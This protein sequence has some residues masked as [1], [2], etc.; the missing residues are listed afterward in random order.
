MVNDLPADVTVEALT[1]AEI[2]AMRRQI[3]EAPLSPAPPGRPEWDVRRIVATL[4][5]MGD[6]ARA[7]ADQLQGANEEIAALEAGLAAAQADF[8]EAAAEAEALREERD[9]LL[10]DREALAREGARMVAER[11][12]GKGSGGTVPLF[13]VLSR[14]SDD[15]HPTG[16][17]TGD[18]AEALGWL[19]PHRADGTHWLEARWPDGTALRMWP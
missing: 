7:N 10:E 9:R 11:E 16:I 14:E 1:A 15:P 6:E 19:L 4:E 3:D 12:A 8:A 5:Q 18:I 2:A 17:E 13:R